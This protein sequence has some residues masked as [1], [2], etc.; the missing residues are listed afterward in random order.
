MRTIIIIIVRVARIIA[1][2][3][4]AIRAKMGTKKGNSAPLS[5]GGVESPPYERRKITQANYAKGMFKVLN[6]DLNNAG[7]QKGS[8]AF[9][10]ENVGARYS[11]REK[12][13]LMSLPQVKKFRKYEEAAATKSRFEMS[14]QER[15]MTRQ[16][17]SVLGRTSSEK[18]SARWLAEDKQTYKS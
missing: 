11:N 2:A 3:S 14:P 13:Y 7:G 12:A 5:S 4:R 18:P 10:V 6:A 17:L 16:Q 15:W 8:L 1:M 9:L